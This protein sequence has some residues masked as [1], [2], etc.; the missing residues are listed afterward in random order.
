MRKLA[1]DS[2]V[3]VG[4]MLVLVVLCGAVF[5]GVIAPSGPL[6]SDLHARLLPPS[7]EHPFGTDGQGRDVLAR[8]LHGARLSLAVGV[9]ARTLAVLAGAVLGLMA[10]AL[11]GKVD[12]LIMRTADVFLAFPS[13]LLL[14]GITAAFEPGPGV[15]FFA[16][17]VVG[18][19]EV[20]RLVRGEALSVRGRE[21]VVAARA[22]GMTPLRVMWRH[23]FPNCASPLIIS[24]SMG[25]ATTILA[26]ASLSFLGLGAQPPM[27][28]W[29]AMVAAG[30]EHMTAAPWI[31][32]FPGVFLA[33]TVLGLNLV[34]DGVR[35]ALDPRTESGPGTSGGRPA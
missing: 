25:V 30:K 14:I 7:A 17:A 11:G 18:W 9:G 23:V 3:C 35:D 19:A 28:S 5:A 12:G 20:A 32:L 34:G 21:F 15:A 2:G 27:A 33:A 26:E 24:F 4:G 29:G 8:T 13:L 31:A 10:G 6:E 16:L 22:L 1:R